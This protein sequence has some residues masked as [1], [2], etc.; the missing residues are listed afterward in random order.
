MVD[1]SVQ[2]IQAHTG[3]CNVS[4]IDLAAN[5]VI[6]K[7]LIY[8]DNYAKE[9]NGLESVAANNTAFSVT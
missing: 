8:F 5:T 6:G 9:G 7:E 3:V 4:V 2:I 1:F